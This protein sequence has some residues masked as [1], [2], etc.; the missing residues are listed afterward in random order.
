MGKR[1]CAICGIELAPKEE[2]EGY[3]PFCRTTDI[4]EV[5]EERRDEQEEPAPVQANKNDEVSDVRHVK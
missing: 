2:L 3:C 1:Y 5:E 4:P